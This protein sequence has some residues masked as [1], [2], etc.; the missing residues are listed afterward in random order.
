MKYPEMCGRFAGGATPPMPLPRVLPSFGGRVRASPIVMLIR[1]DCWPRS[2]S[3]SPPVTRPVIEG[4]T[5]LPSM[6]TGRHRRLSISWSMRAF[7]AASRTGAASTTRGNAASSSLSCEPV[8]NWS[9]CSRRGQVSLHLAEFSR[10]PMNRFWRSSRD[11]GSRACRLP[12]PRCVPQTS[13]LSARPAISKVVSGGRRSRP[14]SGP[15]VGFRKGRQPS[16]GKRSAPSSLRP[17]R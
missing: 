8:S 11:F 15:D 1:G 6:N 16:R 3:T 4:D 7:P 14:S 17:L 2:S 9:K 12:I 10:R 13:T 5:P